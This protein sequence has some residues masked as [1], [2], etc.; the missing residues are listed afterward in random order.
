MTPGFRP[1]QGKDVDL[2]LVPGVES[3]LKAANRKLVLVRQT[4]ER[5]FVKVYTEDFRQ[6]S[7]PRTR[8]FLTWD[9]C[10]L[11][12]RLMFYL[13]YE[14]NIVLSPQQCFGRTGK[15]AKGAASAA[16]IKEIIAV[17]GRSKQTVLNVLASLEKKGLIKKVALPGCDARRKAIFLNP[18]FV[19]KGGLNHFVSGSGR[20]EEHSQE[21]IS[22]GKT[23]GSK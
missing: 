8:G 3:V 17:S 19:F 12:F 1:E 14:T 16:S 4:K 2:V 5:D 7:Q 23:E 20:Q 6:V 11:F 18:R 21:V 13:D 10:A 22:D 15:K 9:E